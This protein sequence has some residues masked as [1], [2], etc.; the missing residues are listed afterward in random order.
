VQSGTLI[1]FRARNNEKEKHNDVHKLDVPHLRQK[2]L[3]ARRTARGC[4]HNKTAQ[5]HTTKCLYDQHNNNPNKNRTREIKKKQKKQQH[6]A[7][8]SKTTL[9]TQNGALVPPLFAAGR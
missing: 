1:A 2:R 6:T 3:R 7:S 8:P 5:Q 9:S 4:R